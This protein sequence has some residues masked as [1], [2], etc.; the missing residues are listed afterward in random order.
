MCSFSLL[1]KANFKL[2]STH[3]YFKIQPRQDSYILLFK[4]ALS[5]LSNELSTMAEILDILTTT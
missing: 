1:L 3:K 4:Y 5:Y 2:Q